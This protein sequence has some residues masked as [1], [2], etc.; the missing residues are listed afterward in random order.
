MVWQQLLL[1]LPGV[2][3]PFLQQTCPHA[4]DTFRVLLAAQTLSVLRLEPMAVSETASTDS[5]L[6]GKNVSATSAPSLF[7]VIHKC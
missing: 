2:L 5:V 6:F 1:F 7:A 4:L 3:G